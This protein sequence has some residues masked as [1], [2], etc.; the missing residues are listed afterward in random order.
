MTYYLMERGWRD[1]EIFKNE[2]YSKGDAWCWMIGAAGWED[3]QIQFNGGIISLKRGQFSHSLRFMAGKFGWAID[4]VK[5]F[6]R[7]LESW[8]MITL[9]SSTGQNIVTICNYE[10][11]QDQKNRSST[12]SST[13][14]STKKNHKTTKAKKGTPATPENPEIP[15]AEKAYCFDGPV[16]RLLRKD[17]DA[18]KS[19]FGLDNQQLEYLLNERDKFLQR[20]DPEDRRRKL[21]WGPTKQWLI[22]EAENLKICNDRKRS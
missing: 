8:S 13:G 19:E 14:S 3:Y 17:W 22:S 16:I 11:Y 21:W 12:G 10:Y 5:L 1:S 4:T 2:K 9:N 15:E 7:L 20:L 18:F 6:L